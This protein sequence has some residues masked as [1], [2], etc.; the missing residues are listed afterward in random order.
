MRIIELIR[1][2][3]NVVETHSLPH[4]QREAAALAVNMLYRASRN[5]GLDCDASTEVLYAAI[6]PQPT[7]SPARG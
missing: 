7:E 1:N 4:E 6:N 3:E 5:L 2:L